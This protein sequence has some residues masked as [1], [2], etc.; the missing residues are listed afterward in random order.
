MA[1]AATIAVIIKSR[2]ALRIAVTSMV[3]KG[4][5]ACV[6]IRPAAPLG[7]SE[8]GRAS[9]GLEAMGVWESF[10]KH[11]AFKKHLQKLASSVFYSIWADFCKQKVCIGFEI[12]AQVPAVLPGVEGA[13]ARIG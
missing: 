8:A 6:T 1:Q 4:G 11:F 10:D 12:S 3:D 9:I 2:N 13:Y 7:V 5:L